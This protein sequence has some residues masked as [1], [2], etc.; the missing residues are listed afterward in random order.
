MGE[1]KSRI[2]SNSEVMSSN[3]YEKPVL[4]QKTKKKKTKTKKQ[5]ILPFFI[6]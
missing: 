4:S 6:H 3:C 5:K 1:P 2:G